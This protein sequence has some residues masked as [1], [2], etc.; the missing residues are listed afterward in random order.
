ME[1]LLPL[2]LMDLVRDA[3]NTMPLDADSPSGEPSSR[4]TQHQDAQPI[5]PSLS[6][7]TL[8]PDMDRSA[9]K[10]V[11]LQ[12]SSLKFSKMEIMESKF[13]LLSPRKFSPL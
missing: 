11:L 3:L 2:V 6:A 1:K 12:L 9:S 8:L 7:P 5:L 4:L 10:T 13:A